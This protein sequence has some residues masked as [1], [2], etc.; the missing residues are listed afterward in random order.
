[1]RSFLHVDPRRWSAGTT[2]AKEKIMS[3]LKKAQLAMAKLHAQV[4]EAGLH[5]FDGP[6]QALG[7]DAN[8]HEISG[9]LNGTHSLSTP[10]SML[11]H[12][13]ILD[14]TLSGG[15]DFNF[16]ILGFQPQTFNGAGQPNWDGV[17]DLLEFNWDPSTGVTTLAQAQ[18]AEHAQLAAN[19]HDVVFTVNAPDVHGT[20]T[21][22]GLADYFLTQNG[23]HWGWHN[24]FVHAV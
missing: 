17:H 5:M 9:T 24:S 22:V 20:I 23:D 14:F 2:F 10:H 1:M 4:D 12:T 8:D 3:D 21:F 7:L 15:H 16:T 13:D 6:N 19:G 11:N 18:A